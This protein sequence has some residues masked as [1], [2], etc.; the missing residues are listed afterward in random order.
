MSL[1]QSFYRGRREEAE[2][3]AKTLL[4]RDGSW[5]AKRGGR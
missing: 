3:L 5:E 4:E 2:K 1:F